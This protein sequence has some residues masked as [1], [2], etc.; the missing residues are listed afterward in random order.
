LLG[1]SGTGKNLVARAIH[2]AGDVSSFRFVEINCAALPA[3]LLEAELFG[4]ERGAFTDARQAKRG[5]VEEA[6]GGTLLLDEI[7]AMP[8]D[9]QAKLLTFLES[10]AARRVG[11]TSERSVEL[12]VIA[13]T[14]SRLSELVR[15]GTFREDLMYR[16]DVASHTLPPLREI[17]SDIGA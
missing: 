13:A 2:A 12:R 4:Y 15:E 8:L 5:L 16:L 7:G 1:E 11:A 3:H 14:N 17:R 9:L 6:D 10:R